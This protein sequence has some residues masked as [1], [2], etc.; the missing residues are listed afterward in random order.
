MRGR[1]IATGRAVPEVLITNADLER[2]SDL[3]PVD[4]SPVGRTEVL[5][6]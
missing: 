4:E 1:I 2:R 5:Y 6:P 3:P